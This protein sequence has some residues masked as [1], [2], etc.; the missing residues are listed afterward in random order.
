MKYRTIVADP[1]WRYASA[2]TKAD[3]SK[4]YETMALHDLMGLP[5]EDMAERDAHLGLWG[6]NAPARPGIP[7]RPGMGIRAADACD[8]VQAPTGSRAL[9]SQQHRTRHL[10]GTWAT[11]GARGE[12][13]HNVVRLAAC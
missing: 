10:G 7:R 13:A 1:P 12:A 4:H 8:V 3:A 5:I 9:P 11:T 6:T 2:A